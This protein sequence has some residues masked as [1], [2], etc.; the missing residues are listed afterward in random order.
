VL[1]INASCIKAMV[2]VLEMKRD[3]LIRLLFEKINFLF[4]SGLFHRKICDN[5]SSWN[6]Q[7]INASNCILIYG[8]FVRT[9]M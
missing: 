3:Y 2:A 7:R 9:W 4:F 5:Q 6:R 1:G 8:F